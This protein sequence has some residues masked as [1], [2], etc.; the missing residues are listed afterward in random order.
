M[1]SDLQGQAPFSLSEHS[2]KLSLWDLNLI[3]WYNLFPAL[4]KYISST[5]VHY[6][7]GNCLFLIILTSHKLIVLDFLFKSPSSFFF[8]F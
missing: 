2:G 3:F 6:R 5:L 4:K 8:F 7:L 1:C